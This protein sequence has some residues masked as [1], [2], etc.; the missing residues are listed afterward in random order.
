ME[1]VHEAQSQSS[2]NVPLSLTCE[3]TSLTWPAAATLVTA[4]DL[5]LL[6]SDLVGFFVVL[7]IFCKE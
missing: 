7:A 3:A 1:G 6:V 4:L 2:H 5:N